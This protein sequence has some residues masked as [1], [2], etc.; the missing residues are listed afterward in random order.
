MLRFIAVT[1]GSIFSFVLCSFYRGL[2]M[3]DREIVR[4]KIKSVIKKIK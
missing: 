1:F 3:P 2:F 4:A